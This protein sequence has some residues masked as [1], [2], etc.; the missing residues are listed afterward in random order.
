MDWRGSAQGHITRPLGLGTRVFC[1]A[2]GVSLMFPDLVDDWVGGMVAARLIGIA[3]LATV[4]AY[5]L[6]RARKAGPNRTVI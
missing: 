1:F 4:I 3:M 5:E 6:N 2:A